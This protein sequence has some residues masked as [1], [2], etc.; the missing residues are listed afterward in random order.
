MGS[1]IGEWKDMLELTVN[2][3]VLFEFLIVNLAEFS[4]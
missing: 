3:R 4:V 1:R 2:F